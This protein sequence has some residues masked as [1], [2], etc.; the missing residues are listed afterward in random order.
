MAIK[1]L[2]VDDSSFFRRVITDIV[3]ADPKLEVVGY[4]VNGREAVSQV[5]AIEPDVVVMDVEMP[6]MDGITAVKKI[7]ASKPTPIL[8][9]SSITVEGAKASLD[10]LD[11]GALHFLPK[12]FEE[13]TKDRKQAEKN[14]SAK[15]TCHCL[16]QIRSKT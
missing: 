13:I 1:V 10:A 2:V 14:A 9:F 8:M 15:Y 7:M 5:L 11:A 3:N 4:A 6:V 12:K 16:A